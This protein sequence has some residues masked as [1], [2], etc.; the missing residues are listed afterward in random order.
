EMN[1]SAWTYGNGTSSIS[2]TCGGG[3]WTFSGTVGAAN[4]TGSNT[5][6]FGFTLQGYVH[7]NT[8]NT[9][10]NCA[11][12]DLSAYSGLSISLAS[13][14]GAI[15]SVGIGVNLAD[16]SKGKKEISVG[17]TA[18]AVTITWSQLGITDASQI[19]AIWGNFINGSS[20]V[21]VDLVIDKFGLQ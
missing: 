2:A 5:A 8:A 20:G 11:V 15:A 14:S 16:G 10:P 7:D 3:T 21:T 17:T 19:T 18:T 4:A 13:P 1:T 9:N 6:G 12:F